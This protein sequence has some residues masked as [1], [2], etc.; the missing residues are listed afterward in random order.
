MSEPVAGG[1]Y[2]GQEPTRRVVSTVHEITGVRDGKPTTRLLFAWDE[3]TDRFVK[4]R[5]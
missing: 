2:P 4:Q 3:A 1:G 5:R